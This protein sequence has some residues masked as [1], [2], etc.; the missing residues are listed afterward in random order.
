[1]MLEIH[2]VGYESSFY[3]EDQSTFWQLDE[4]YPAFLYLMEIVYSCR[5]RSLFVC[6]FSPFISEDKNLFISFSYPLTMFL[7]YNVHITSKINNIFYKINSLF[8][9]LIIIL[10]FF[11]LILTMY[12]NLSLFFCYSHKYLLPI[13][14]NLTEFIF[15]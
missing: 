8:S 1:M 2:N 13:Y 12:Y 14:I 6:V 4:L 9:C 7:Q 5:L 11:K 3:T 15:S 10:N